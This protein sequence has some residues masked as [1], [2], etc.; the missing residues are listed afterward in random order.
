MSHHKT[1]AFFGKSKKL[2][3]FKIV[4]ILF[5]CPQTEEPSRQ[6]LDASAAE[7]PSPLTC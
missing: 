5:I 3:L 2:L 6:H 1:K 4:F 7:D